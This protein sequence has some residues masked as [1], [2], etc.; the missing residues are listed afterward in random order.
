MSRSLKELLCHDLNQLVSREEGFVA[1]EESIQLLLHLNKKRLSNI[2]FVHLAQLES[3]LRTQPLDEI[4]HYQYFIESGVRD[5]SN[6]RIKGSIHYAALDLFVTKVETRDGPIKCRIGFLADHYNGHTLKWAEEIDKKLKIQLFIVGCRGSKKY[7][8]DSFHCPF[9]TLRHLLLTSKDSELRSFLERELALKK[10]IPT[11]FD[12][13]NFYHLYWDQLHPKYIRGAQSFEIISDYVDADPIRLA[14]RE[15]LP[16]GKSVVKLTNLIL[17]YSYPGNDVD[18]IRSALREVLPFGES[19]VKLTNLILEYSYPGDDIRGLRSYKLDERLSPYLIPDLACE[20]SSPNYLK[21]RN[22]F[23]DFK[24]AKLASLAREYLLNSAIT[25]RKLIDICYQPG[26]YSKVRPLL[27]FA[28]TE[29]GKQGRIYSFFEFTFYYAHALERCNDETLGLLRD[30]RVLKFIINGTFDL[31]R[32]L[33]HITRPI[34]G[35]PHLI[36]EEKNNRENVSK[37]I[38]AIIELGLCDT[39]IKMSSL[40]HDESPSIDLMGILCSIALQFCKDRQ[41]IEAYLTGKISLS[42]AEKITK[43]ELAA[44]NLPIDKVNFFIK[45]FNT[46]SPHPTRDAREEKKEESKD[47]GK[48][49]A[50]EKTGKDDD[51]IGWGSMFG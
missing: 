35:T 36:E 5:L 2:S 51:N 1:S 27:D 4:G 46:V 31:M 23:I 50:A 44:E 21:I 42:I 33:K 11:M 24:T 48:G 19:G 28:L 3:H 39:I 47:N 12:E 45:K 43:K 41:L 22:K 49:G 8:A 7:Q 40:P 16:F 15:V 34:S 6:Q 25:Q 30:P 14:L 26:R 18:S 37:K 32:L 38:D 13:S 17:E 29:Q 20:R 10:L 9:F